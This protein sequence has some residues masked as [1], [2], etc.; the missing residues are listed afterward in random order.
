MKGNNASVCVSCKG[1]DMVF[2]VKMNSEP[3]RSY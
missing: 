2:I 3:W 1:E